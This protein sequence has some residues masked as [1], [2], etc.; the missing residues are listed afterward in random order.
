MELSRGGWP[1][2][3]FKCTRR[4]KIFPITSL[5]TFLQGGVSHSINSGQFLLALCSVLG[6]FQ[7]NT[8][9]LNPDTYPVYGKSHNYF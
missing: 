5:E 1:P 6:M 4:E 7:E 3:R 9:G 8:V 2:F